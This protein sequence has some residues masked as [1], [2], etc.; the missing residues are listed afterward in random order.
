MSRKFLSFN[1]NTG[2][3]ISTAFEDGKNV[4]KYEQDVSTHLDRAATLRAD[5]DRW[6]QGVK[7]CFAHAAF[8]PDLVIMDMLTRFGVNFYD[9]SQ[10]KRVMQLIETEYP[11]CKT[12]D[13][14][15]G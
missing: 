7:D 5:T 15:I 14:R 2:L 1:P 11:K 3:M 9:K 4:V 13:K 8:V 12:T 10:T 6:K